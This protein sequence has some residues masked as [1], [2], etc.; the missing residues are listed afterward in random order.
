MISALNLFV[1]YNYGFNSK[2]PLTDLSCINKGQ[3]QQ[4][5]IQPTHPVK[6]ARLTHKH[7]RHKNSKLY[8]L[9]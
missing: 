4:F 9:A 7:E 5:S 1:N 8:V 6:F 3:Y 2:G